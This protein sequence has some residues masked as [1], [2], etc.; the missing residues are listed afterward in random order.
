MDNLI[1]AT[2]IALAAFIVSAANLWLN[3]TVYRNNK[4]KAD[5][6]R[7]NELEASMGDEIKKVGNKVSGELSRFKSEV[8]RRLDENAADLVRLDEAAEHGPTHHDLGLLHEK[9]N[10]VDT[11]V[12]NI[13]GKVDG[14]DSNLRLIMSR[15][16]EK[17]LP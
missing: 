9:I 15:I 17:G 13:D 11:K 4:S 3:Y 1:T 7:I 2:S 12:S 16:M 14:I 10:E 6:S 5:A 8:E